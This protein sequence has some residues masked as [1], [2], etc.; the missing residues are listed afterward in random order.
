MPARA[1]PGDPHGIRD[2]HLVALRPR[3]LR[4]ADAVGAVGLEGPQ[5]VVGPAGHH[6]HLG[7]H[8]VVVTEEPEAVGEVGARDRELDQLP[9]RDLDRLLRQLPLVVTDAERIARHRVPAVQVRLDPR[10]GVVRQEVQAHPQHGQETDPHI[11]H[12]GGDGAVPRRSGDPPR[13]PRDQADDEQAVRRVHQGLAPEHDAR[14]DDGVDHGS[15]ALPRPSTHGTS[16]T[17]HRR[18][19]SPGTAVTH[20][21]GPVSS[22]SPRRQDVTAAFSAVNDQGNRPSSSS[23]MCP[24]R[25]RTALGTRCWSTGAPTS[26]VD[27]GCASS[28]CS[29]TKG[30]RCSA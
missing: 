13:E 2:D 24:R 3:V 29:R 17:P 23:A 1:A 20:G 30:R 25:S 19:S 12:L 5:Q 9:A 14:V 27:S 18:G 26:T 11:E 6:L 10:N 8:R 15:R 21:S 7:D 22:S 4:G 16:R 28:R